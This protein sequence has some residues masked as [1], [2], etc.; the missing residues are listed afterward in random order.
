L[1]SDVVTRTPKWIDK[2]ALLL[3]HEESLAM[4]GGASGIRDEGL[5]DS[6]LA[7]PRN[8][9]HYEKAESIAKLAAAYGFGIAKNYAFVDGNKRTALLAIGLFLATNGRRLRVS[10]FE[11]IETMLALAAG[12]LN[13][14]KLA[15]WID[16]HCV[17]ARHA[18]HK[19]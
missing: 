7:R 5:L 13:E 18:P 10:Q 9:F 17:T 14:A 1:P 16:E 19:T 8:Q 11:A 6:A 12:D 2:R 4:F 15:V 3:L